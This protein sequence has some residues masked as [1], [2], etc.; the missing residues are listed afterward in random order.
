MQ[1]RTLAVSI[2]EVR[3]LMKSLRILSLLLAAAVVAPALFAADFGVR[4][5]RFNDADDE[6]VGAEMVFDAGVLNVNPNVEYLL[7]ENDVTAGTANLDVTFDVVN[8]A[9]V[10]PYVGAGVGISYV[11]D[12]FGGSTTDI[13]GNLIGGLS[14]NL[15]FLKPY[16]QLKYVR[17][18]GN[19]DGGGEAEDDFAIAV[20]LRF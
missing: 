16:A 13:V 18:L 17:L 20:G 11:D 9:R 10:T 12:D 19:E 2:Q 7:T 3:P 15:D 5:G 14:F 8:I 1:L 4:A 6:F